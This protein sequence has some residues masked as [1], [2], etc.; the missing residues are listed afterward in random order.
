MAK[1]KAELSKH[2]SVRPKQGGTPCCPEMPSD[3][4]CDVLDFRYRLLHTPTVRTGNQNRVVP[5]EVIIHARL[6]RCAGPMVLGDLVYSTT[7]L[8]GEK[9][10]LFTSDRRSSFTFDS[11]TNLSYRHERASEES[12][13]MSSLSQ[14][15]SDISTSDKRSSNTSA[16]SSFNTSGSTS[17]LIGSI[18]NGPSVSVQGNFSASATANFVRELN[19]HA[20]SSASRSVQ[21]TRA[22][23]SVSVGEVQNR[24][25]TEGES[26]DHFEASSRSFANANRCRAVSYLF[27][28][29]N[30]TQTIK[31]KLVSISRRVL[32]P[33]GD[34]RVENPDFVSDGDV[35]VIPSA[36][37]ATASSRLEAEDTGRR[38]SAARFAVGDLL[39]KGAAATRTAFSTASSRLGANV[40]SFTENERRAAEA[41]VDASLARVGL[42]DRKTKK[43]T[44]ETR[45]EFEF[46][47]KTSIPTPG[48]VVKGCLDDCEVCEPMLIKEYELDLEKKAL[49]N[50]L[51][52]RQVELLDKA[53]EYRCCPQGESE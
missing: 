49:E 3:D 12:Y 45:A 42:I 34:T 11:E 4:S 13:L 48:I 6:E 50:R 1:Q 43:P 18:V 38:S 36:V 8:P 32:D 40:S 14:M 2:D 15:M 25:H 26:E 24:T 52:E 5:V 41:S 33:S 17:G 46:V 29:V 21:A 20:E 7:L 23:A 27:Y 9:V 44:A 53:S 31:L 35:G 16:N 28:Q 37:L 19:Q 39:S 47:K 30:K 10:R 22:T 51:L